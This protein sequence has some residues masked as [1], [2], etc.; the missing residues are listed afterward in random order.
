MVIFKYA[1]E[2]TF[3][4]GACALLSVEAETGKIA[5]RRW[6]V[7]ITL[8]TV[9]G[10]KVVPHM[11]KFSPGSKSLANGRKR[12]SEAEE[13]KDYSEGF[14]SKVKEGDDFPFRRW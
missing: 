1:T 12:K 13:K 8:Q 2:E 9:G 5:K 7:K 14:S 4:F 11:I 10:G 3:F 6:D